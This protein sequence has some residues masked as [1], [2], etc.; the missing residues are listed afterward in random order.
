M[1]EFKD[2]EVWQLGRQLVLLAYKVANSLPDHERWVLTC[3]IKRTA[4]TVPT[5]IA[6]AIAPSDE[7]E[8]DHRLSNVLGHLG[9]LET[10][11]TLA[12]DLGYLDENQVREIEIAIKTLQ[13]KQRELIAPLK[14]KQGEKH[15]AQLAQITEAAKKA[16]E[17]KDS[18]E[19]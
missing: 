3:D 11:L 15:R 13:G 1:A 10:Q 2:L 19:K 4:I 16:A 12:C 8:F 7:L 9:V 5:T 14:A 17:D 6:Q 18:K